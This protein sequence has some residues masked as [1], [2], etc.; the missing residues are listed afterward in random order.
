MTNLSTPD[1]KRPLR[2]TAAALSLA[3]LLPACQSGGAMDAGNAAALSPQQ[4][5]LRQQS[6]RW[7]QTVG[8][9]A[10]AGAA[11][12]AAGGALLG[13]KNRG[14]AT[15]IGAGVGAAAGAGAGMFVANRS[16]AF[17]NR[18]LS[19][20]QRIAEARDTTQKFEDYARLAADTVRA[21]KQELARLESEHRNGRLTSAQYKAQIGAMRQDVEIIRKNAADASQ[22]LEASGRDVRQIAANAPKVTAAGKQMVSAADELEAMM[23]KSIT[24]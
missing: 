11:A 16:L 9:G 10:L 15:L 22:R 13:G 8:T 19:A 6:Q 18:E 12:G 3:L 4:Q 2:V 5:M 20:S 14:M 1:R 23:P 24:G 17:E 21:N 7:Y